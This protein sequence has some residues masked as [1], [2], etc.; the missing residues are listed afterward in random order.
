MYSVLSAFGSAVY[1][2][3][4]ALLSGTRVEA[5]GE[6]W[7]CLAALQVHSCNRANYVPVFHPLGP[8]HSNP[9]SS[10]FSLWDSSI[11]RGSFITGYNNPF[12]TQ[13]SQDPKGQLENEKT[14]G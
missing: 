7:K 14:L 12:L 4:S 3:L 8:S 5:T 1:S 6:R 10:Q 2:G 9:F 11:S 13:I